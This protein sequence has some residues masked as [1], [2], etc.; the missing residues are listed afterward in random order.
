MPDEDAPPPEKKPSLAFSWATLGFIL[1]A[2]F[3]VALP[4]RER[5]EPEP[6]PPAPAPAPEEE[7]PKKLPPLRLLVIEAVF[8]DYGQYAVWSNDTTEVAMFDVETKDYTDCYQVVRSGADTFFF[9]TI[10][11]LT[12]PVLTHG[13]PSNLPL[14]FTETEEQR[15]QWLHDVNDE[16]VRALQNALVSPAPSSLPPQGKH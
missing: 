12:R 1:G 5:R 9:R 4:P 14:R 15:Q 7:A 11:R 10:P 2:L 6:A 8:A 3:V 13:V 16:N